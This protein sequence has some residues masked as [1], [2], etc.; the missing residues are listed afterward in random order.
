M[1]AFF[2]RLLNRTM[3]SIRGQTLQLKHIRQLRQKFPLTP[4]S[5][6]QDAL[7][8]RFP[9]KDVSLR[10]SRTWNAK[11]IKTRHGRDNRANC[12]RTHSPEDL[13]DVHGDVQVP[14]YQ[15]GL[16]LPVRRVYTTS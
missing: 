10:R 12:E 5:P 8:S 15:K 13:L 2:S 9:V 16:Q 3:V 14:A 4:A 11:I 7:P 6:T 1:T